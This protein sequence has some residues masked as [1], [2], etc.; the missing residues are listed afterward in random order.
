MSAPPPPV[1]DAASATAAC[2]RVIRTRLL[3]LRPS[4]D[5]DYYLFPQRIQAEIAA[6]I[7]APPPPDPSI[8]FPMLGL[9]LPFIRQF[10]HL[11]GGE[12]AF[13]GLSTRD[14]KARFIVPQTQATQL[15]LC[16]QMRRAGDARVRTATWFVSHA[17]SCKFL[18]LASALETFFADQAGVIIWMDL[19]STSQHCT[20]SKPPEWWQDAFCAAIGRMGQM[21]MVMTPWDNPVALTR[22]WCLIELYACR[23]SGSRLGIAFPP[24]E[25]AR[26]LEDV[27][28]KSEVFYDMLSKVNARGRA[29][30]VSIIH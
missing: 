7:A 19:F 13:D 4:N 16:D 18:D 21:V 20:F 11:N 27:V 14:V 8:D 5:S 23:S 15:S 12:A 10:I 22:A 30:V 29:Q 28:E 26:F 6:A 24:S 17:W 3:E 25:R 2:L 9:P 1:I